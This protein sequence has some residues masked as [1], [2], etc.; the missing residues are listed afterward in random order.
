MAATTGYVGAGLPATDHS[1]A[2]DRASSRPLRVLP[3]LPARD[4]KDP[5]DP[6]PDE[7]PAKARHWPRT[8]SRSGFRRAV[9]TPS[10]VW[11][12]AGQRTS[13]P[14]PT[15]HG[16]TS[17]SGS[18]ATGCSGSSSSCRRARRPRPGSLSHPPAP[19]WPPWTCPAG[20][21]FWTSGKTMRCCGFRDELDVE[22]VVLHGVIEQRE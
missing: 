6:D 20:R 18:G 7:Q 12:S 5:L 10:P 19:S 15:R 16:P 13:F 1:P 4:A 9:P 21:D 17:G 11:D 14:T 2:H 22:S 8:G 3:G